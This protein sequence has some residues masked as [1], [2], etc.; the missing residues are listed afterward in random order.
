[1]QI[2]ANTRFKERV[3]SVVAGGALALGL[4]IAG[5]MFVSPGFSAAFDG[6]VVQ[7]EQ[8]GLVME[9]CPGQGAGVQGQAGEKLSA[10]SVIED[11]ANPLAS[12]EDIASAGRE[13][14]N[15]LA[16]GVAYSAC[17]L[18]VLLAVGAGSMALTMRKHRR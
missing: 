15:G 6:V 2:R 18:L 17:A 16:A 8:G 3:A 1:M 10:E 5:W 13:A 12:A 4:V 7:S 9:A 11:D 14:P